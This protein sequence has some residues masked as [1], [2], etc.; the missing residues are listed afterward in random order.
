MPEPPPEIAALAEERRLA[1]ERRDFAAADGVR[2]RLA[3][4]GWEVRDVAGGFELESLAERVESHAAAAAAPD[5]RDRPSRYGFSLCIAV[6]GWPEDVARLLRRLGPPP[7]GEAS[8]EV[9]AVDL[10]GDLTP[11]RLTGAPTAEPATVLPRVIRIDQ[12]LG[13]AEALNVAAHAALGEIAVFVEPSLS[14]DAT[15]LRRLAAALA[16]PEVGIAGPFGLVTQDAQSFAPSDA[17]DVEALEYLLAVRR[18]DLPRI[19]DMDPHFRFYRMLDVDFC[20]QVAAA[21]LRVRRVDVP[22]AEI[23]R[24]PHRLWESTPE[25]ERDRLSRRNWNRFRDRWQGRR[26]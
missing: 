15:V 10:A 25:P 13:Q 24:H 9:V 14:F 6:H 8:F 20:H 2:D 16:A 26:E 4:L 17:A 22:D 12:P 23:T 19:G 7:A 18:A 21:G 11:A 1:R 5:N 3:A